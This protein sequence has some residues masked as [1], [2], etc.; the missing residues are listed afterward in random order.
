MRHFWTGLHYFCN[1]LITGNIVFFI[2][3]GRL[4]R[5]YVLDDILDLKD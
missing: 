4:E 3:Y 2:A 5:I 1:S